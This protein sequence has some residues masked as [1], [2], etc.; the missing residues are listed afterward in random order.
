MNAADRNAIANILSRNKTMFPTRWGMREASIIDAL[1]DYMAQ[2]SE[3]YADHGNDPG[4]HTPFDRE[5][6]VAQAKG[7]A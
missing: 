6:W 3:E 4:I 5:A 1:G 7:E 2:D